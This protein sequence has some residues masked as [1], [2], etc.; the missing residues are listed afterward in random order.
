M[1]RV[2]MSIVQVQL[3]AYYID[4]P[5]RGWGLRSGLMQR[6]VPVTPLSDIPDE[7][8][9]RVT[10]ERWI[11]SENRLLAVRSVRIDHERGI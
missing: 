3:A 4:H 10:N 7:P 6:K 2:P 1:T 8:I 11:L 9:N 5:L